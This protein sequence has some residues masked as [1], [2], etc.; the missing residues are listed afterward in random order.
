[1]RLKW[2]GVPLCTLLLPLVFSAC[3]PPPEAPP[4]QGSVELAVNLSELIEL[5]GSVQSN[6]SEA[7]ALA[8]ASTQEEGS[9]TLTLYFNDCD[10]GDPIFEA[11]DVQPDWLLEFRFP[12]IQHQGTFCVSAELDMDDGSSYQTQDLLVFSDGS[13]MFPTAEREE[14]TLPYR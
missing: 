2:P 14:A 3:S 12:G 9:K 7:G 13:P 6:P 10:T 8:R 4:A 11:E 5:D 1:M